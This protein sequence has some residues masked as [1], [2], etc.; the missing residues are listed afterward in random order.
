MPLSSPIWP[1]ALRLHDQHRSFMCGAK[2]AAPQ[3]SRGPRTTDQHCSS[4]ARENCS[5]PNHEFG[6]QKI[7]ILVEFRAAF[8]KEASI[9][10]PL[11]VPC[12]H[13]IFSLKKV[14]AHAASSP[15]SFYPLHDSLTM[16]LSLFLAPP[17][18]QPYQPPPNDPQR[19]LLSTWT[20]NN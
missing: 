19:P 8:E 5:T 14:P 6:S 12:S 20:D 10:W 11:R 2:A 15:T 17:A 13:S 4:S 9:E 1:L 7:I 18:P 16:S 3:T